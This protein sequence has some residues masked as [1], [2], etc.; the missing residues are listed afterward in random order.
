MRL[1][2]HMVVAH[3]TG[4]WIIYIAAFALITVYLLAL[5]HGLFRI[6]KNKQVRPVSGR[7]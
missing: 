5:V 4:L 3:F 6:E 7:A 1:K 2:K